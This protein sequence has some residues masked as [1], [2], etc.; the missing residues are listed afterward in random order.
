MTQTN[1][2]SLFNRIE[3]KMG[4]KEN[5]SK[6]NIQVCQLE[7]EDSR[8]S[9]G[10]R[11]YLGD[12]GAFEVWKQESEEEWNPEIEDWEETEESVFKFR[13]LHEWYDEYPKLQFN[14]A[15]QLVSKYL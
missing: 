7:D 6:D 10:Y 13:S 3:H 1:I 9:K 5:L 12:F 15:A 11:V 14:K 4:S 8:V 2:E